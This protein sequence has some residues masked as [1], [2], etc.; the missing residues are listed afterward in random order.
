MT[1]AKTIPDSIQAHVHPDAIDRVTRFFTADT[2]ETLAELLQN[3]RRAHATKVDITIH[4]GRVTISDDGDGITDP[5]AILAFGHADWNDHTTR[6]EDPAGMGFYSL[7]QY[8]S[9]NVRSCMRDTRQAW[10]VDLTPEHF[11]GR[12]PAPLWRLPAHDRHGT[13][14]TFHNPQARPEDAGAAARFYPLPVSCNG[15]LLKQQDYLLNAVNIQEWRGIRIGVFAN[16]PP[17]HPRNHPYQDHKI[18]FHGI[19]A[20]GIDLPTVKTTT[21]QWWQAL[22][23]IIECPSLQLA[24]PAR[25]QVIYNDFLEELREACLKAIYQT[26][27]DEADHIDLPYSHYAKAKQMGIDLPPARPRL[28]PWKPDTPADSY[29]RYHPHEN[30][31]EPGQDSI[32]FVSGDL[33]IP[34]QQAFARAAKTTGIMDRFVCQDPTLKGYDWYDNIPMATHLSALAVTGDETTVIVDESGKRPEPIAPEGRPDSIFLTLHIDRNGHHDTIQVPADAAFGAE[35]TFDTG[36]PNIL[37]TKS[38]NITV[39]EL[40]DILM[41]AYYYPSDDPD[42]DSLETQKESHYEEFLKLSTEFLHS[43]VDAMKTAIALAVSRH[44]RYHLMPG[45]SATITIYP[46]GETTVQLL[47]ED[48]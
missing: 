45:Y 24:L 43:N 48:S 23:D 3:S 18:N 26:I 46:T 6:S 33:P 47:N 36:D 4:N 13:V 34:D 10:S 17:F 9:V 28:W 11:L 37:V 22:V 5:Q 31:T 44:V 29:Y 41:D 21:D 42:S 14:I 16:Q 30:R 35:D 12:T 39:D 19:T 25:R 20:G 15:E 1:T 8:S 32:L 38:S 7:S 2:T 40:T 27:L